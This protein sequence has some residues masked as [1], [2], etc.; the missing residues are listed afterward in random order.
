MV[1]ALSEFTYDGKCAA[2]SAKNTLGVPARGP[3][4]TKSVTFMTAISWSKSA[5]QTISARSPTL[6]AKTSAANSKAPAVSAGSS[7]P[8]AH[9]APY[10][11]D[12]EHDYNKC[13]N[14]H[15]KCLKN[16]ARSLRRCAC[17]GILSGPGYPAVGLT[18]VIADWNDVSDCD[19]A[20]AKLPRQY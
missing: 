19:S 11:T 15:A 1:F 3:S 20:P 8:L 16:A 13:M 18:C 17:P 12:W 6:A 14:D 7:R 9:I 10:G 4:P 5:M 2:A